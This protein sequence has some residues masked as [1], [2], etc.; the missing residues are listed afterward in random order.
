MSTSRPLA[1]VTGASTG[2]GFELAKRCAKEG[3]DLMIA[4]DEPEIEQAASSLRNGGG[5]TKVEVVQA[6]LATTEGVDRLYAAVK[7]RQVDALLANAGRGLGHGFLDQDFAKARRVVD[8]NI[9]GTIDLI[10]K[11]GNDM[12]RRNA[13]KILITGSIAGFT[14]GSFQAV[15]NGTK[16]FLNSFSFALREELKDTKVTVT[17]L[18]PGATETEFFKRAGMMDTAVGTGDKDDAA[19]VANSGFDAM[20]KGEGDVVTG[21]KTRVQS[22]AANVTPAGVLASQ[23]RKMA[24]PGTAKK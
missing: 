22:A 23:H 24:E 3:Y 13:G 2:I 7:G 20:I 16:A 21:L 5:G 6:D 15:Y 12:R 19:D 1:I 17:C 14:P 18:M 10:Y 11:V 9:T 8:T 4:A